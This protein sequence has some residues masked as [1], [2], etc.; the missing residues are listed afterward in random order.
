LLEIVFFALNMPPRTVVILVVLASAPR[1]PS[2][3]PLFHAF[4]PGMAQRASDQQCQHVLDEQR[5]IA[6]CGFARV[7]GCSLAL[8]AAVAEP[9]TADRPA[10]EYWINV[11]WHRWLDFRIFSFA[12]KEGVKPSSAS[13]PTAH[14]RRA[15]AVSPKAE[16]APKTLT[17]QSYA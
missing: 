7:A 3:R 17:L 14:A 9:C 8:P 1:Y 12:D 6:R 15:L 11:R 13:V 4:G 5:C 16:R 10:C 2:I